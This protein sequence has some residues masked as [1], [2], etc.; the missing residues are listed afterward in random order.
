[1]ADITNRYQ[2]EVEDSGKVNWRGDQV[3]LP[4]GGQ[5][6]YKS[7]TVPLA[8]LGSRKVVGDRVFRYA[9]AGAELEAAEVACCSIS[10]VDE[11]AL[12]PGAA[13]TVGAKKFSL[14]STAPIGR[15]ALAEGY[16]M[17][18]SGTAK[19]QGY[20]YRIKSHAAIT[21]NGTGDVFLY[22]TIVH[23]CSANDGV[24]VRRNKYSLV[25]LGES[26]A[27]AA[28]VAPIYV[29][30][31]DYLWLQTW[32]PCAVQCASAVVEGDICQIQSAGEIQSTTQSAQIIGV[33]MQTGA[34]GVP[35]FV[36]LCVAP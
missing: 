22:D 5:S 24:S 29:T 28:G 30:S 27:A 12:V 36:D 7:S 31:N 19:N 32:G 11:L 4:Q 2:G 35:A 6:I 33:A 25:I 21:A 26:N 13:F 8:Q 20:M 10:L 18:Q 15:D 14:V 23:T 16:M 34:A 9:Q 1:M 3:N 17:V